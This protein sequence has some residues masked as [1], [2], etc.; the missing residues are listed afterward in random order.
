MS[1]KETLIETND[2]SITIIE[3]VDVRIR[4]VEKTKNIS[5]YHRYKQI[6]GIKEFEVIFS[7]KSEDD[8]AK[9][10][11]TTDWPPNQKIG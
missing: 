9:M 3:D 6:G 1:K 2:F 11:L 8:L 5:T 10:G 7:V 4:V